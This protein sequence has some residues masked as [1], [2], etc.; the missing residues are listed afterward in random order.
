MPDSVNPGNIHPTTFSAKKRDPP[1]L[2]CLLQYN[3]TL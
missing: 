2:L 1:L 3:S